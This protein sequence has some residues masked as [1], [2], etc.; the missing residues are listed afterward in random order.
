MKHRWWRQV[1]RKGRGTK[2]RHVEIERGQ[3]STTE[4]VVKFDWI[5]VSKETLRYKIEGC[6]KINLVAQD[7]SLKRKTERIIG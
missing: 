7:D 4:E 1:G 6:M 5:T 2:T 3:G